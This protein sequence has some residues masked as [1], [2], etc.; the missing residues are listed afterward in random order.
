LIKSDREKEREKETKEKFKNAE[1]SRKPHREGEE[2]S[3]HSRRL[4]QAG[5][6][7]KK[8]NTYNISVMI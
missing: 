6:K 4:W 2:Q 8:K 7:K 1:T 3:Q 5:V